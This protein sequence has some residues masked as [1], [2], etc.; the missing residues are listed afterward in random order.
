M[1]WFTMLPLLSLFLPCY[2]NTVH[3]HKQYV[4]IF[5]GPPTSGKTT[6]SKWCVEKLKWG[7]L[8]TEHLCNHY[9]TKK[10]EIGKQIN[11]AVKSGQLVPDS[12]I[13]PIVDEQLE[14]HL[15]TSSCVILEGF[16][17]TIAQ[18]EA[19]DSLLGN[20]NQ[21]PKL[22]VIK[23]IAQDETIIERINNRYICPTCNKSYFLTKN[24]PLTPQKE[25]TCDHCLT[26]LTRKKDDAEKPISKRL[27]T[28]RKYESTMLDFYK[29]KGHN[30]VEF[31]IE[32]DLNNPLEK[33]FATFA[34]TMKTY[35]FM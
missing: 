18:A 32:L 35:H 2:S 7:Y 26:P 24:S 6:L 28:Y 14:H 19:L 21:Q 13:L 29:N 31:T 20:H 25:M 4:I 10:T 15:R 9:A 3:T 30:I 33:Q 1:K 11:A 34:S 27:A 16:P 23:L 8:A 5:L 22:I 12:I 17:R